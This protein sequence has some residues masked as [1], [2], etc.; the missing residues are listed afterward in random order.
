MVRVRADTDDFIADLDR[1][2]PPAA[3]AKLEQLE[4]RSEHIYTTPSLYKLYRG[5]HGSRNRQRAIE[6]I[7]KILSRFFPYRT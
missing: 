7:E 2:D 6:R 4:A 1:A 3:L 5:A